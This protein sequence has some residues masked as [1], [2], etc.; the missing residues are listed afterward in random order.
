MDQQFESEVMQD[1]AAEAPPSSADD[2][3]E[4][5][6]AAETE[7]LEEDAMEVEAMEGDMEGLEE[8]SEEEFLSEEGFEEEF[9]EDMGDAFAEE[10]TEDWD[11]LEDM[12]ADTLDAGDTDEFFSR[13]LSGISQVAGVAGRG[14]GAVGRVARTAGRT[15][16]TA[17]RIAGQARRTA[18]QVGRVAGRVGRVAGRVG[19]VAGRAAQA[20]SPLRSLLG[21]LLPMI[22]QWSQQGFDE[23]DALEDLADLFAEEEM[24]E[25][26]PVLAGVAARTVVRPLL[27]RV[28]GQVSHPLRR[29]LVHSATQAAQT[30]VRRQGPQALR[31]LPRIAQS[32]GRTAARRR[33]RPAALPQ[34][35]RRTAAQVA[36]RPSLVR[37][38]AQPTASPAPTRQLPVGRGATRR[39][40]LSGPV[41]IH[42]ISR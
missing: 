8:G 4:E 16:R 3:F 24:D 31:A 14:A 15:A 29:Q 28:A 26:L 41:E 5:Y 18:G 20:R 40:R 7:G 27:R 19:Q 30:L 25:A 9:A 2:A 10:A 39:F 32:V 22:R 12:M 17:E 42:I 1:L 13:L 33:L 11:S 35:V 23:A 38:L 21:Q 36:A 34:A 6:D 37:R